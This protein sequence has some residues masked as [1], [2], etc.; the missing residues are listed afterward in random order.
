MKE[1][2]IKTVI[3]P[4]LKVENLKGQLLIP[5]VRQIFFEKVLGESVK[6]VIFQ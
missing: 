2:M 1:K 4:V 5:I 6:F 3:D